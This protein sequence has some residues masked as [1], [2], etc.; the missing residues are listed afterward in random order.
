MW[1]TNRNLDS[2]VSTTPAP[3]HLIPGPKTVE[4]PAHP[5]ATPE[6][7]GSIG[8]SMVLVGEIT[9]TGT[10]R[11]VIEGRVQGNITL[12]GS[13]V[14]VGASGRVNG[15]ITAREIVI[16]G[17]IL[18]NIAASDRVEICTDGT[19]TG[20][21]TAARISIGEDATFKGRV[22]IRKTGYRP[23][24]KSVSAV[25]AGNLRRAL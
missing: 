12:P 24:S 25:S 10:H 5:A 7:Q 4:F 19:L 18:G 22:D 1:K 13:H 14:T 9:G 21:L 11:L 8:K 23:E 20:D 2:A 6:V 17:T 16:R 3:L 15:A